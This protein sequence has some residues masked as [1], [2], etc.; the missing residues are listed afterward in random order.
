MTKKDY[1]V[2]A[3]AISTIQNN[4]DRKSMSDLI[5]KI[6]HR[7]HSG[8]TEFNWSKWYDACNCIEDKHL[9]PKDE[10]GIPL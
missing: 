10:D 2:L 9:N 8:T 5:G 3:E 1:K 6:C 4:A 7:R